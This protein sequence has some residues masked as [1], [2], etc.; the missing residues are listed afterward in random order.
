MTEPGELSHVVADGPIG[1]VITDE[2]GVIEWVNGT[3]EKW[4]GYA[5]DDLIG[6]RTFQSLLAPGGRIYFDTH[7]RP[8]LHLQREATEVA[9]DVVRADGDRL[10]ALVNF[11]L[12]ERPDATDS[13]VEIVVFDATQRRT[14]EA[15]L[16][17]AQRQAVR[18][19][20]R[21]Q[22][23]YDIA[24]GMAAAVTVDDIVMVVAEQ[25][26]SSIGGARCEVWMFDEERR[27]VLGL[28][29]RQTRLTLPAD[30]PDA[31]QSPAYR[32]LANGGL[33]VIGDR[34]LSRQE[35]PIVCDWMANS[36]TQSTVIAPLMADGRLEGAISYGFEE[37]HE[38]DQLELRAASA[39]AASTEE[40]L[41]RA[42][43]V[44]SELRSRQRLEM[45]LE[46]AARLSDALSL[47]AVL[48]VIAASS[49]DLLGAS[50][51][52]LA[53][54]DD[55]RRNLTVVRSSSLYARVGLSVPIEL[56]S[57]AS[58]TFRTNAVQVAAGR[59]EVEERFPDSPFLSDPE[60]G[61]CVAVPLHRGNEVIGAWVLAFA[62]PAEVDDVTLVELFAAQ[63]AQAAQRASLH[64]DEVIAR[65]QAE[66]RLLISEA[67]NRAVTT[68]DVGRAITS[69]GRRA[70]DAD[71]LAVFVLDT[72]NSA[73]LELGSFVGLD[74][75]SI[76]TSVPVDHLKQR[77]GWAS[78]TAPRFLSTHAEVSATVGWLVDVTGWASAALLPL[79][80]AGTE[81]GAA[82]V[83]FTDPGALVNSVRV[84]LSG[85]AAEA[86]VALA[87]ARRFDVEHDIADTLQRSIL[88]TVELTSPGWSV[89]TW[90][91]PTSSLLVGGDL[92]DLTE[93][94]DGRL[95][96]VVG[97]VVGHGLRAAAAMGA[98]RSAAKALALVSSR[99]ADVIAGLQ[100][101]ATAA[102]GVFCASVCC[103]EVRTDG[104]GRYSSAGHP[105]PVLRHAGGRT[106]LLDQ[107]R[108]A[109]LGIAGS[110]PSDAELNMTEGST[111][112]VYT[113]GLVERRSADTDEAIAHLR[114]FVG[115][116]DFDMTAHQVVQHMLGDRT[117]DDDAV[118]VC[119]T[120]TM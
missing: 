32:Q 57:I 71:G 46:F 107:G 11:R 60:L 13:I 65:G 103:I 1:V 95:I 116:A 78:W 99:P 64:T 69:E 97:D 102:P 115:A 5:P 111:L 54:V 85:L 77:W 98:L 105:A 19:E 4:L 101:F 31:D 23:M 91:Q 47:D 84:T 93:L 10:S 34:E 8:L 118:V 45:L 67:L 25:G 112:V 96:L 83:G 88:P 20:A 86:S 81:L 42:R 28:T 51:V 75:A 63:A 80:L 50:G 2:V 74:R 104:T 79:G 56:G 52:T 73:L 117:T 76:Q 94:D 16:L 100:A 33:V 87:R 92:F 38:F 49:H 113:D 72:R 48:D 89:S 36:A 58:T 27:L 43:L 44:H 26:N 40:A 70:F 21:L 17:H 12:R 35:Y 6:R 29:D 24:S 37:A 7:L 61:G 3:L 59:K 120:R 106:E 15:E 41:R 90:Y 114:H 108:S 39:L 109:L 119:L 68:T 110:S 66:V 9:L 30:F 82:V 62:S 18:S 55:A 14:Y 53:L 22:V